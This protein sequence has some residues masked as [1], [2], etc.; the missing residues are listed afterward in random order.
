MKSFASFT[1]DLSVDWQEMNLLHPA[2]PKLE[3]ALQNFKL[4]TDALTKGL[5]GGIMSKTKS[6]L[7]GTREVVD[8]LDMDLPLSFFNI[9]PKMMDVVDSIATRRGQSK[10]DWSLVDALK[11]I[12]D[13]PIASLSASKGTK[14]LGDLKW[15]GHHEFGRR[16]LPSSRASV[17]HMAATSPRESP[18]SFEVEQNIKAVTKGELPKSI[19]E[20]F[21]T[22]WLE[23]KPDCPSYFRYIT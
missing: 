10:I 1:A 11:W 4:D 3:V 7:E 17:P 22:A 6:V 8:F 2:P 19:L 21:E 5:L 12:L 18:G 14:N 23:A 13:D 15:S 9:G 16:L 20:A